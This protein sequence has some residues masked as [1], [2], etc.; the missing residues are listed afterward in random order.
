[1]KRAWAALALLIGGCVSYATPVDTRPLLPSDEVVRMHEAGV[2]ENTL[3]SRVRASRLPEPVSADEIIRLKN[4]NVPE[5]V[6]KALAE[7][8]PVR[9]VERRVYYS[10][11]W[12]YPYG[13]WG[14]GYYGYW[15]PRYYGYWGPRY[16][17]YYGHPHSH[18][19]YHAP[20]Y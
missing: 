15:G 12:G 2:D 10:D 14:P 8:A 19:Y 13:H 5:P 17:G 9:V 1:M 4:K 7:A 11:Y 6:I 16:Y 3:L 18:R 20:R